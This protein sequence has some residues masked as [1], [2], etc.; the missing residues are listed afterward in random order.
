MAKINGQLEGAQF[1]NLAADP[2][3]HPTGRI[4]M[5]IA[6]QAAAV[7]KI[8]DGTSWRSL[9]FAASSA[10]VAQNSGT[11][12]TVDW[13]TGL[14]QQVTLTGHCVISFANPSEGQV[15]KLLVK[16]AAFS[17]A[18]AS[19]G[20][21]LNMPDQ[22]VGVDN[23]PYQPLFIPSRG[24]KLHEWVYHLSATNAY[25]TVPTTWAGFAG[26]SSTLTAIDLAFDGA[27]W[28]SGASTGTTP[29]GEALKLNPKFAENLDIPIGAKYVVNAAGASAALDGKFSPN[30]LYFAQ[31]CGTTPFLQTWP[32][33]NGSNTGTVLSNPATLPTG[34]AKCVEWHPR[35]NVVIAGTGTTPFLAGYPFQN[36]AYGTTLA[37]PATLP[38]GQVNGMQFSPF[39]DFLALA[40]NASPF[41]SVYSFLI[42]STTGLGSYGTKINDPVTLPAAAS[43]STNHHQIAWR[44]QSDWIAMCINASPWVYLVPFNRTTSTFGTP[45]TFPAL[46]GG[47]GATSVNW[48]P[49]GQYL[50]VGASSLPFCYVYDF[51]TGTPVQTSLDFTAPASAAVG[52]AMHPSGKWGVWA[53]SSSPKYNIFI[54]PNKQRNYVRIV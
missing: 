27:S 54:P 22:E 32:T 10:V 31:V 12:V 9:A 24:E 16:Q 3:N 38:A 19:F 50:I 33:I 29:F 26:P 4:Y 51:S 42:N 39:G 11:A 18:I 1:E 53:A 17:P 21:A 49:D 30:G 52:L 47:A 43:S 28:W 23:G 37:N 6:N 14:V 40:M 13:S 41:I 35:G 44:P 46:S 2:S 7:P 34:A 45:V 25:T 48:T 5:N 36:G 20:Y 8:Y 15:H